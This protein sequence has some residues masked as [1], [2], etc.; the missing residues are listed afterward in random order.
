MNLPSGQHLE[1]S[2]G[3]GNGSY[4]HTVIEQ[5]VPIQGSEGF[6]GIIVNLHSVNAPQ[7]LSSLNLASDRYPNRR[8]TSLFVCVPE[9][10]CV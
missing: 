8:R 5:E 4:I 3:G 2:A 10:C 1:Y 7:S 9:N 6:N